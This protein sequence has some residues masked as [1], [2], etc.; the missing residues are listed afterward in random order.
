MQQQ[1]LQILEQ[2]GPKHF[3]RKIKNT[4]ELYSVISTYPGTTVSEQVYNF[5]HPGESVCHRGNSKIFNSINNGYRYCGKASNCQCARE[6]VSKNCKLSKQ[7]LTPEQI[8][9]INAKRNKTTYEKYGVT[10]NGQTPSAIQSRKELYDDPE[11]VSKITSKVKNTK[12]EKYGDE[13]YNNKEQSRETWK[14]KYTPEYWAERLDNEQYV[15]LHDKEWMQSMILMHS[16]LEISD[17][18]NVH[19]QTVYRY[20]HEHGIRDPYKSVAELELVGFLNSLGIYNIVR[21]TRKLIKSGKEIDLYLPD[22]N[23]AIEYDGVYWHHEDIPHITRTYH[24]DKFNDCAELGIQ[25]ITIFSTFWNDKKPI[26]KQLLINKLGINQDRI[27]ARKC[28]IKEL[29]CVDTKQFLIDNHIQGY[30]T[31]ELNYGLYYNNEL[32]SVMSFGTCNSRIGI[33]K[34]EDGYELIRY[35]TSKR[36]VGGASKLLRY[37]INQVQPSKIVSYS[38]NEW[39]DG[40]MYKKIGFTLDRDIKPSYCYISPNGSKMYHR[41]NFS[42]Q[43]LIQKGYDSSLTEREITRHMGLMKLWDCGK[44]RWILNIL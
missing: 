11:R 35:A 16:P 12:F 22:Y 23:I 17:I 37:F 14:I 19:V 24:M 26:V 40:G 42:K 2:Y 34:K 9:N 4:P 31:A 3:A 38:N 21:N 20:L 39:S 1:I 5:L 7:S 36:V 15:K 30:T 6:S 18:L 28:I 32:V 8:S 43:K 10:N 27:H 44:K 29:Q 13:N 41:F 25:L 33:G